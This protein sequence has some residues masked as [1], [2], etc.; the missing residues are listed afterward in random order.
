MNAVG[1]ARAP[2]SL[3]QC[4]GDNTPL[5]IPCLSPPRKPVSTQVQGPHTPCCPPQGP[6]PILLRDLNPTH[7]SGANRP[8]LSRR[9]SSLCRSLTP[10]ALAKGPPW[11][12]HPLSAADP[13]VQVSP[14]PA[15]P[16]LPTPQSLECTQGEGGERLRKDGPRL[17]KE[18]KSQRAGC[19]W[20]IAPDPAS[21]AE[22]KSPWPQGTTAK[23]EDTL[24]W[25]AARPPAGNRGFRRKRDVLR[26]L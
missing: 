21:R 24:P 16:S 25:A 7:A 9:I 13:S 14:S 4:P 11:L 19:C 22:E 2:E 26:W 17:S 18:P 15:A 20:K 12:E 23:E 1:E 3:G 8:C 10:Q 5:P 6:R